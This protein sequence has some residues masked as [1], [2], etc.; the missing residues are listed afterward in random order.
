MIRLFF[1]TGCFVVDDFVWYC[2][3]ILESVFSNP[4]LLYRVLRGI[5]YVSNWESQ[6]FLSRRG[7]YSIAISRVHYHFLVQVKASNERQ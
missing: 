4:R 3:S 1:S 7:I 5:S 6:S 2:C